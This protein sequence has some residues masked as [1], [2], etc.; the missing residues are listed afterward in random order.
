M[1]QQVKLLTSFFKSGHFLSDLPITVVVRFHDYIGPSIL[2]DNPPC[3]PICIDL[4]I[5]ETTLGIFYT[6]VIR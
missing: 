1:V 4:S 2:H 3:I 5:S 6:P